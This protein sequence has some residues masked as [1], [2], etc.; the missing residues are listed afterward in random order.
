LIANV[1]G[2]CP[3]AF[4]TYFGFSQLTGTLSVSYLNAASTVGLILIGLLIDRYRLSTVILVSALGSAA[5]AFLLWGFAVSQSILYL[6][7]V[8]W[9]I[10]AGGYTATWTGCATKIQKEAPETEI[11]VIMGLMAAGR[12]FG[13][14]LSGPLSEKVISLDILHGASGGAYGTKYGGLIL[15][16]GVTALCGGIGLIGGYRRSRG[17]GE[18]CKSMPVVPSRLPGNM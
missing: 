1:R 5:S 3:T 11:A 4:A 12:G 18:D 17:G 2:F 15:F 6:F 9:G 14:L 16:T 10:F 8:T 13:C 7:A